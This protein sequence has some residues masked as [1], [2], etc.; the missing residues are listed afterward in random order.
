[1][2]PYESPGVGVSGGSTLAPPALDDEA[3]HADVDVAAPPLPPVAPSLH[4]PLVIP[5]PGSRE[6]SELVP[7]AA[8]EIAAMAERRTRARVMTNLRRARRA[9]VVPLATRPCFSASNAHG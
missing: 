4:P 2:T 9:A 8:I 7:H 1:M 3:A 6:P 5:S